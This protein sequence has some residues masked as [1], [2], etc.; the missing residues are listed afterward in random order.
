MTTLGKILVFLVFFGALAV[1]GLM[2]F[3]AK[4]SPNWKAAVKERD[5]YIEVLKANTVAEAETKKKWLNEIESMKK[6]FDA[7]LI[8]SKAIQVKLKRDA[9]DKALEAAVATTTSQKADTL[10]KQAQAETTRLQQELQFLQGV[11]KDRDDKIL[12]MQSDVVTAKNDAQAAKNNAETANAR[13]VNL[14]EKVR[15]I[16][17]QLQKGAAKGSAGADRRFDAARRQ[18]LQS[19]RGLGEGRHRRSG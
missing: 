16:E 11:V 3:V 12:A 7:A 4:T 9:D 17:S 1:G 13:A 14:L 18:L 6:M 15:E 5:D 8:E 2:V 10:A 19:A